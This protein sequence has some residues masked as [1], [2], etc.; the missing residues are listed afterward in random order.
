[1]KFRSLKK[2]LLALPHVVEDYLDAEELNR[3]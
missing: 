2:V 3:L 1:M